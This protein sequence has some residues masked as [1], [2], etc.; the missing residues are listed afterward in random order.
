MKIIKEHFKSIYQLLNT[1]DKR[2]N[3]SA[4]EDS[5]S[6]RSGDY[7]FTGSH[8]YEEAV[9]LFREGYTEILPKVMSK[10]KK[11]EKDL[12]SEFQFTKKIRP[13]NSIEGVVP[14]VPNAILGLPQS[15]IDMKRFPQKQK[16]LDIIYEMGAN[17]GTDKELF[18]NAGAVLLTV[19]KIL[20]TR[21]IAVKLTLGFMAGKGHE[22][23][24]FPTVDL[25]DYGQRLDLQK[26]CFPLA[27]PSMFR[28]IGF[29]WLET[30]PD[31]TD[32]SFAFEYGRSP[33]DKTDEW[34]DFVNQLNLPKNARV[35]RAQD[36][37]E[38][39]FDV[40]K[41]IDYLNVNNA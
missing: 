20:E 39:K 14:N 24:N 12:S 11:M 6:S 30:N 10:M 31:I 28:R 1:L 36:I 4:M 7:D 3:N 41:L 37:E 5:D 25:K 38:M 35:L 33:A 29:K 13:Q 21:R 22:Q 27:H 15:M 23:G 8:S 17:C 2:P 18:I 32:D 9:Q 40:G 26:L 34:K 19:I 16:T